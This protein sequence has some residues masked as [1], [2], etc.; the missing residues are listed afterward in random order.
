MSDSPTDPLVLD[1][2][3]S[4]VRRLLARASDGA[5]HQPPE[6]PGLML[7]RVDQPYIN[8]C[9]VYEPCVAVIVQGRKRVLLGDETL[10]YGEDRYL[11]TSMD[12]P[13]KAAVM[14]ATPQQPYL[15]VALRLDWREI[16]S[17][18]LESPRAAVGG[19]ARESRAMSTGAVSAPLLQ[20]FDRLLALL[21]QPEHIPALAPLVRREI[22]YRLLVGEAGGRLRQIA[23]VDSQSQL[24]AR[25][26][27]RLNA[28]FAQPLRV[29]ALAREVGMSV[30]TF[31]HHFKALTAMSPLQY[32]KQ[33]RLN[34][35][36]RLM[37]SDR[38]DAASAAFRVG[39]ESPSQFSREYSRQFGAP[40]SRD[41]AGLRGQPVPAAA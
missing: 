16:A 36:R 6:L 1:A 39:Y 23:T 31:H 4:L 41:M 27:A 18:V 14:E 30:S 32:Q 11:I 34:E 38:L 21:D 29:E 35:A 9:G 19:E 24:I 17:L 40:P 2:R 12:L 28:S 13:V 10:T 22:F 33:L 3:A 25:A 5:L 15:A 8:T 7:M 37:L 26:I 20:A